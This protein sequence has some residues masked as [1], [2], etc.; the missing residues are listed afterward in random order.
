MLL[1]TVRL[2]VL[3]LA[4]YLVLWPPRA[5]IPGLVVQRSRL[6]DNSLPPLDRRDASSRCRQEIRGNYPAVSIDHKA[7]KP[8][9][10]D[11]DGN[12]RIA[13]CIIIRT[14]LTLCKTRSWLSEFMFKIMV[15]FLTVVST[16]DLLFI[17][18]KFSFKIET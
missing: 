10:S 4:S 1:I 13:N 6:S 17:I 5:G 15:T 18:S 3:N 9:S 16:H 14:Y 7:Q 12:N 11:T 8:R 2:A